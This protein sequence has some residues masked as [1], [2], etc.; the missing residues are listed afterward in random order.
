MLCCWQ[1]IEMYVDVEDTQIYI[2][3]MAYW[4]VSFPVNLNWILSYVAKM[5]SIGLGLELPVSHLYTSASKPYT[6]VQLGYGS[7]LVLL[8]HWGLL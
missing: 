5:T 1:C 3:S 4:E 8:H 7:A 6:S 2:D